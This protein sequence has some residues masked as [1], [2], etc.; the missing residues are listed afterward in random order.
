MG[1]FCGLAVHRGL[2]RRLVYPEDR[3]DPWGLH[4]GHHD[5]ASLE[6]L[7]TRRS[8]GPC[9]PCLD[10]ILGLGRHDGGHLDPFFPCHDVVCPRDARADQ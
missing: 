1:R 2:C 10:R 9:G 5:L 8:D 4:D 6:D 3:A 7:E